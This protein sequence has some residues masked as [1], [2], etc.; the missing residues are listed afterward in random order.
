MLKCPFVSHLYIPLLLLCCALQADDIT[1]PTETVSLF[2]NIGGSLRLELRESTD[3]ATFAIQGITKLSLLQKLQPADLGTMLTVRVLQQGDPN[4]TPP[5]LGTYSVTDKELRF[6]S[7]F[8]L[9]RSLDYRVELN[10]TLVNGIHEKIEFV[11][12]GLPKKS[13]PTTT[14]SAVYPSADV[15]PENLL[16]FYIHFS[17]PMSRGEAY[18]RIHLIHQG[19]EVESPFLELG[20]ELWDAEQ[21]RFTVFVHP[22]RIKKGLK[23]REDN[24][25]P[26][27][28]GQEYTLQIDKEWVD[29]N[30]QTLGMVWKKEFRVVGADS[31]QPDPKQWKIT[32]PLANT[33]QPLT[34]ALDESLDRA[35]LERV[36]SV[37]DASNTTL[38]GRVLIAK[39][40]TQWAFKPTEPWKSGKY[41]IV[42][43]TVIEDLVGNNLVRPF[44]TLEQETIVGG[45][46]VSKTEIALA[47]VVP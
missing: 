25:T 21:K 20:E 8:P 45:P 30:Q 37:R 7:R 38:A 17:S 2:S 33:N 10:S 6:S 1:K 19:S 14:V 35:M 23:P 32:P 28:E 42:F 22:G 39:N 46:A 31:K 41:S 15:L 12:A 27:T 44:E 9:N 29:A 26:M 11:V 4:A 16:K 3:S 34:I 13:S 5:L 18:K 43:S 40:E 36:V 47:F 24:G